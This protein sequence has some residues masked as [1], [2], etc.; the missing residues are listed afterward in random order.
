MD[1]T[2]QQQSTS[3]LQTKCPTNSAIEGLLVLCNKYKIEE[4]STDIACIYDTYSSQLQQELAPNK[5]LTGKGLQ[6]AAAGLLPLLYGNVSTHNHL[7]T[8]ALYNS[9]PARNKRSTK[10]RRLVDE[11]GRTHF[12]FDRNHLW[13]CCSGHMGL[14]FLRAACCNDEWLGYP[15]TCILTHQ[16]CPFC[17]CK[18]YL[19]MQQWEH[20]L[21]E[22]TAVRALAVQWG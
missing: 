1:V 14:S 11:H 20:L 13:L 3:P 22:C 4:D 18:G 8:A 2:T 16:C 19:G 17:S 12:Y 10:W 21:Q 9:M 6:N 5:R 15:F 7:L